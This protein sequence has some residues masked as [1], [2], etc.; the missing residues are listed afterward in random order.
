MHA[1]EYINPNC[2]DRSYMDQSIF[3]LASSS[4]AYSHPLETHMN[5]HS[6]K[7][8]IVQGQD[9]FDLVQSFLISTE[10]WKPLTGF[11]ILDKEEKQT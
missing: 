9:F 10:A 4:S 7:W 8:K 2:Q 1:L 5:T 11:L 3:F 6:W